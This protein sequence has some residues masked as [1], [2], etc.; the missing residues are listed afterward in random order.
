MVKSLFGNDKEISSMSK[1]LI[2][3]FSLFNLSGGYAAFK[4]KHKEGKI[5]SEKINPQMY[6]EGIDRINTL[7]SKFSTLSEKKINQMGGKIVVS[8]HEKTR[9]QKIADLNQMYYQIYDKIVASKEV[10]LSMRQ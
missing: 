6:R 5:G 7:L 4:E 8:N 1:D 10:T 2:S 3:C 9:S